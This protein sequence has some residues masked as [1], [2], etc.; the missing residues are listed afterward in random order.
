[1][2]L[3]DPRQHV[4]DSL[5]K[6]MLVHGVALAAMIV[7]AAYMIWRIGWT[8]NTDALW[9]ALP[10]LAAELHGYLTYLG[11]AFITW[12]VSPLP[13]PQPLHGASVDFLIPTYNEPF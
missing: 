11:F 9:I 5:A 3:V 7:G 6:E 8:T 4:G 12:N 1:M 13:R 10:L 2:A